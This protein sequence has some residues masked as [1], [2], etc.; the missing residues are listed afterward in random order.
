[1]DVARDGIAIYQAVDDD[2]PEPQPKTPHAALEMAREY[3]EE[4]LP[5]ATDFFDSAKDAIVSDDIALAF[6]AILAAD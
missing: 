3:F 6:A 4:W 5:T 2:L 1:M